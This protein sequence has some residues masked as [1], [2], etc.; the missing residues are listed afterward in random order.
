MICKL[1]RR[2]CR[3]PLSQKK[4]HWMPLEN[5]WLEFAK[6]SS[7]TR[8]PSNNNN[9][10]LTAIKTLL[11]APINSMRGIDHEFD[12]LPCYTRVNIG[13]GAV[14]HSVRDVT[15]SPVRSRLTLMTVVVAVSGGAGRQHK[16]QSHNPIHVF[17]NFFFL[18]E[19]ASERAGFGG[20]LMYVV[21]R[22]LECHSSTTTH[23]HRRSFFGSLMIGLL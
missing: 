14:V 3:Q 12:H 23:R 21:S 8:R 4:S 6:F 19:P 7:F 22:Y 5:N 18:R 10:N 17:H 13:T 9:F 1:G 16:S 15:C 2:R 11:C 20:D